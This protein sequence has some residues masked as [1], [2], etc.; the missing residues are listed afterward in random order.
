MGP[1][2]RSLS[3]GREHFQH[4]PIDLIIEA[5]GP[6]DLVAQ[7]HAQA[8]ARFADVLN[9]L[10]GELAVLRRP[11]DPKQANPFLGP[12]ATQ[13]WLACRHFASDTFITPMA[14]VAGSVAQHMLAPYQVPGIVRAWVNNGGDIAL[15]LT[16]GSQLRLG[17]FS[18]LKRLPWFEAAGSGIEIELDGVA[19]LRADAGVGGVATSGWTGRSCSFGIADSVTVLASTASLADAAATILANAVDIDDDSIAR[20]PACELWDDSDLGDRL[21]TVGVP[22]LPAAKVA[23]ALETGRAKAQA[24]VD[25]GLLESVVLVCQGQAV[26]AS[27]CRRTVKEKELC[28]HL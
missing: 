16:P 10:V 26:S 5:E 14:A 4:G 6:P 24:W 11:I 18:D 1:M 2:Y 8:R 7:A 20:Q 12:V 17:L 21:V 19:T 3:G 23:I 27:R 25:E 9:N 15:H 22:P 13:M 28:H